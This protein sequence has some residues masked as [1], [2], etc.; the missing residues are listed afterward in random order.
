[1]IV[2]EKRSGTSLAPIH[3]WWDLKRETD[4]WRPTRTVGVSPAAGRSVILYP[5]NALVEDQVARLR[6]AVRGLRNQE[7]P[8]DLWFGR[9]TGAA[10]G[11]GGVPAGTVSGP[12]I[13]DAARD[14]RD[15]SRLNAKLAELDDPDL[16]AQ[17][18]DPYAGELITRWD[19]IAT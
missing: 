1:R 6:R 13:A 14:M 3:E 8:I 18:Q 4:N 17:F 2:T 12:T 5:T 16:I 7:S 19:M 10:P 9:Y 11:S 15:L